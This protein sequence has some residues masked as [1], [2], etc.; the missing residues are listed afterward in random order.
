MHLS[1]VLVGYKC[2]SWL[3][4]NR[5]MGYVWNN[6]SRIFEE[7]SIFKNIEHFLDWGR[8]SQFLEHV[9][10]LRTFF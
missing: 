2:S 4:L 8:T 3:K 5:I 7:L 10:N 1:V 9:L 6:V